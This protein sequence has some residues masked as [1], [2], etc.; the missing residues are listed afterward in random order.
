MTSRIGK[1]TMG[2]RDHLVA[3]IVVNLG[4]MIVSLDQL[5]G[6]FF[7]KMASKWILVEAGK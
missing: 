4:L 5:K 6:L 3:N 2:T 1:L 7:A